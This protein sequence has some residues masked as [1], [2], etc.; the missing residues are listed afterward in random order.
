MYVPW[1]LWV[2][3]SKQRDLYYFAENGRIGGY[4]FHLEFKGTFSVLNHFCY[5]THNICFC[6]E[7]KNR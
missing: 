4:L 7:K 5:C 3:V 6:K 1:C 2:Y